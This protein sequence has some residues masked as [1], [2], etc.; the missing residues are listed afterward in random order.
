MP[1]S[2]K[3]ISLPESMC[4]PSFS[5]QV[6]ST[7]STKEG[8]TSEGREINPCPHT[9]G[10][11]PW[12][13]YLVRHSS[14]PVIWSQCNMPSIAPSTYLFLTHLPMTLFP[15]QGL[16]FSSSCCFFHLNCLVSIFTE[17]HFTQ[18]GM[19]SPLFWDGGRNFLC[20]L[21]WPTFSIPHL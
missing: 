6:N 12:V 2:C 13:T 14:F 5:V 17:H 18:P 11:Q 19:R 7:E 3:V 15:E 10:P 21:W 16:L 9:V 8:C 20:S 4:P 1:P